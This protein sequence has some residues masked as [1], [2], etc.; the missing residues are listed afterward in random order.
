MAILA[1]PRRALEVVV[2]GRAVLRAI[3]FA[4]VGDDFCNPLVFRVGGRIHGV[5]TLVESVRDAVGDVFA[6]GL[7]NVGQVETKGCLIST[8]DE[9]VRVPGSVDAQYG[10]NA[11]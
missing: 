1:P 10:S 2:A 11:F 4:P 9:E 6:L 7:Q 8:H 3:R 5:I